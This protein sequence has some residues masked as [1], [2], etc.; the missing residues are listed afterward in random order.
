MAVFPRK[1]Q[2]S[3]EYGA[4]CGLVEGGLMFLGIIGHDRRISEPKVVGA[5]RQFGGTF[6]KRFGSL[7]CRE[8]HPEG[9]HPDNP[10]QLCED[11]TGRAIDYTLAFV[12]ALLGSDRPL[13]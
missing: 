4:Q 5:C 8:L 11:L 10:P 1:W 12:E 13:P 6:E 2:C 7:L 9:F 3:H